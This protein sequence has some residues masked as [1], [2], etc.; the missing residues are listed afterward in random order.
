[1]TNSVKVSKLLNVPYEQLRYNTS[2]CK[3]VGHYSESRNPKNHSPV[4]LPFVQYEAEQVL[5]GIQK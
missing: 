2:I 3:V 1:M 5:L 4:E